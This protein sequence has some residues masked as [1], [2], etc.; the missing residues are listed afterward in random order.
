MDRW[1]EPPVSFAGL[2]RTHRAAV[3][4]LPIAVS[5]TFSSSTY[6]TSPVPASSLQPFRSGLSEGVW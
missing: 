6:I 1:Y 5:A 2:A 3:H 4:T